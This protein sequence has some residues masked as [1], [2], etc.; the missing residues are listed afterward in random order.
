MF[1]SNFYFGTVRN[2]VTLFGS[3]FNNINIEKTDSNNKVIEVTKVPITYG[4]KDKM[5]ARVTED[6]GIDRSTSI[7][8]PVMSFEM[9]YFDYDGTRKLR[10]TGKT[11]AKNANNLSQLEY[12]YNPVPYNIGFVL[13]IYVKN[14]EDGTKIIEQI[15]PYFTPDWTVTANLIPQ[16]N[17]QM[18][19]PVVLNKVILDDKYDGQFKDRRALVW[20]LNFTLKGYIYGPIKSKNIIK[21]INTELFIPTTNNIVDAIGNIS[22]EVLINIQPGIFP[23]GQPTSNGSLSIPVAQISANNNFGYVTTIT[24]KK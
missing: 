7:Q 17:I 18:D 23:N 16:L 11:S 4:P 21:F 3:L 13:Y 19:I 1:G 2:Y 5:L 15:L 6:P 24:E 14:T 8:L 12:Q 9:T 22:S 10:T 20:Q